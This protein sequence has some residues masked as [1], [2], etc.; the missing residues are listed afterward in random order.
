MA[1]S[2]YSPFIHTLDTAS[3]TVSGTLDYLKCIGGTA[4]GVVK[5][6][7]LNDT[8]QT[9]DMKSGDSVYGPFTKVVYDTAVAD[10]S[11][12]V[13]ERSKVVES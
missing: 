10:M 13:H 3:D 6:T 1:K 7:P 12:I 4:N 11:V 5:V 8:E 9:L 2:F